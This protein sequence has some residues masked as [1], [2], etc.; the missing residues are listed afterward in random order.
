MI[1]AAFAD[2]ANAAA[3]CIFPLSSLPPVPDKIGVYVGANLA[4]APR[5]GAT[6]GSTRTRL[7]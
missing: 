6:A 1:Q 5:M 3:S 2:V 7:T 4:K